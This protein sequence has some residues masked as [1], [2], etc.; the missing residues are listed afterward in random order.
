MS[1]ENR[2]VPLSE[3]NTS[4]LRTV[5]DLPFG[6]EDS[7]GLNVPRTHLLCQVAGFRFL[8]IETDWEG[9]T[10]Q[11][12]PQIVGVNSQGGA[13]AGAASIK[14][15]SACNYE[16]K[17][18]D[19]LYTWKQARWSDL[20]LTFNVNE[21]QQRIMDSGNNVREV[22]LWSQEINTA[23]KQGIV[24]AGVRHLVFGLD[25]SEKVL[26][27]VNYSSQLNL[28]TDF[29]LLIRSPGFHALNFPLLMIE[30]IGVSIIFNVFHSVNYGRERGGSGRRLSLFMGPELDRAAVLSVLSR[31]QPLVREIAEENR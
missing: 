7:I 3:A 17:G 20:R 5:V 2:F 15:V 12:V 31:T 24:R 13:Y 25:A 23:L 29:S 1:V 19:G 18:R 28:A 21:I 11:V 10:S 14:R 27:A 16:Y 6:I 22:G 4:R 30:F 9:E 26:T 8:R